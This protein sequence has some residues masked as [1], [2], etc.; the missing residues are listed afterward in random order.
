MKRRL[1]QVLRY[2]ALS[3]I[4]WQELTKRLYKE[5]RLPAAAKEE[6]KKLLREIEHE[7]LL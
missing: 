7:L 4:E 3:G 5:G 1:D 2:C 6:G